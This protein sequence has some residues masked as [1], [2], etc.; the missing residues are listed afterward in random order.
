MSCGLA[1][2]G[3][4]RLHGRADLTSIQRKICSFAD[5]VRHRRLFFAVWPIRPLRLNPEG[6]SNWGNG[7]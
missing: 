1:Q 2:L 5:V 4:V 6:A 3:L 7:R